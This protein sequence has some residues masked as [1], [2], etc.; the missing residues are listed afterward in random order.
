MAPSTRRNQPWCILIPTDGWVT[1]PSAR[2]FKKDIADMGAASEV[3]LSMRPVTFRFKTQ[4]T[5]K[6]GR[7]ISQFGLIA[8][9][10]AEVNPDLILRNKE[11][12]IFRVR[13]DAVNAMLL[14]EF[15]KEHRKNREQEKT[16]AR[17]QKQIEAPTAGLQKVNARIEASEAKPQFTQ[18]TKTRQL[19]PHCC[20]HV[21]I[22]HNSS[23][24]FC[25]AFPL[26][27]GRGILARA[28]KSG[29]RGP[30]LRTA[31]VSTVNRIFSKTVYCCKTTTQLV[32]SFI[33]L[34]LMAVAPAAQA[35][36]PPPDGGYPGGNTA[37]GLD[38]C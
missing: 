33:I 31:F 38:F 3:L 34:C 13:Y 17:Q 36:I 11:G 20:C 29:R 32:L 24:N 18:I 26:R 25:P 10:V 15:L 2:R 7:E 14:N 8:E 30:P 4:D 6:A 12:E 22:C 23:G 9:E 1:G 21:A 35:V 37:E 27:G 19:V 16:I 5:E 28:P